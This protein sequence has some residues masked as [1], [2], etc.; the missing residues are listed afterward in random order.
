MSPGWRVALRIAARDA[1]RAKARSLLVIVMIA[2]PVL[3]VTTA[4]VLQRTAD[5]STVEGLDRT[6]GSAQA[7]VR[8]DETTMTAVA[9]DAEGQNT[10]SLEDALSAPQPTLATLPAALG[11]ARVIEMATTSVQIATDAGATYAD[12]TL[13]DLA[14]PL[15][16]GLARL[17]SGRLP[18]GAGEVGANRAL[19]D[20]GYAVGDRLRLAGPDLA[21]PRTDQGPEIVGVVESTTARDSPVL[22]GTLGALP[23][24]DQTGHT[25]LVGGGPVSWAQVRT[26]NDRGAIVVSRA[27]V[28]D[29]PPASEIPPEVQSFGSSDSAVITVAILVVTMALL[30]V[31]LLAGPAFAVGTRRLQRT[32]ALMAAAG[33]T[34]RQARRVVLGGAV[35]L[36]A[37]AAVVGV[38]L[39]VLLG[40]G[41]VPVLQG[42]SGSW[43]GPF[44]VPVLPLLGVAAFGLLSAL[45]A[46]AVPAH[47]ASRQDVVA[48]LAG[49]RGD[50]AP[51]YRSPVLGAVL[52]VVGI[53]V[54]ASGASTSGSESTIAGAALLSVLGMVLLVP[55]VVALVAR[56]AGRLPLSLRYAARDAARHRTRT[57]PAVAAVAASVAG[58]VALLIANTSDAAQNEATYTPIAAAGV[59]AVAFNKGVTTE[60]YDAMADRIRQEVPGART[61]A[62]E[63]VVST[64]DVDTSTF[65]DV[66]LADSDPAGDFRP[67]LDNNGSPFGSTLLVSDSG[68]PPGLPGVDAADRVAT[69]DALAQGL[70]VVFTDTAPVT[71]SRAGPQ[72][73]DVR[74]ETT[75]T[76]FTATGSSATDL[77]TPTVLT[78][79]ALLVPVGDV[80]AV[81]AVLPPAVAEQ[82]GTVG[83]VGIAVTGADIDTDQ[84]AAIVQAVAAIDPDAFFSVERGYQAE[85]ETLILQLILLGLGAV[86]ML[87][88]TLTAT[89]LALADARPDLATLAAIGASP[90]RRRSIAAGYAVLVGFV[91]AVLG[92]L[93]GAVP[94][95]AISFPLTRPFGFADPGDPTHYLD[96]PWLMI[97]VLV[98]VLPLL[99]AAIVAVTS[100]ARL[101][102]V[103][104]VE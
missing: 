78:E 101:P 85:D 87:G 12:A 76:E 45:L 102:L 1:L 97:G 10:A 52:L 96:V 70:P 103:A 15:A 20:E 32:L 37:T 2:L 80:V 40:A 84:E 22:F 18:S 72:E 58:V 81:S 68:L 39:G 47:L 65:T 64:D 41:L 11:G 60:Q 17:T 4:V 21:G 93:V 67:L 26:L 14:D 54:A 19:L 100:R 5:V 66:Q 38:L 63:G 46:A 59:G 8:V 35:V 29:P 82:I 13:V 57:V 23:L 55:V 9:Q 83:R 7:E 43:F 51:S 36:G 56:L 104:R 42:F 73:V 61:T 74:F 49:R 88:G 53:L 69:A 99:T 25:Y 27:V 90:R 31:V 50:R 16:D 34:P 30:E 3:A 71:S 91:G 86:L 77:P 98:I 24:T 79:R 33:G 44:E 94:G 62:V 92:A 48:V 95:V 75:V 28:R 6:L 89:F